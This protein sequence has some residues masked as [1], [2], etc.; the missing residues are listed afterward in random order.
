MGKNFA[1]K[2]YQIFR[3]V[4]KIFTDELKLVQSIHLHP[5]GTEI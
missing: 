3:Q 5:S 2:K 1:G 4:T